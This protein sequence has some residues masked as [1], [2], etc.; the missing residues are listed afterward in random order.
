MKLR[1]R[2]AALFL[3][4]GLGLG[5]ALGVS[6]PAKAEAVL[7]RPIRVGL[8]TALTTVRLSANGAYTLVNMATGGVALQGRHRA[9]GSPHHRLAGGKGDHLAAL[10]QHPHRLVAGNR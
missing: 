1:H 8:G 7:P 4:L 10:T 2:A 5:S 9:A 3:A 6:R